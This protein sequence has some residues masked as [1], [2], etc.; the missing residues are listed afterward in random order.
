[1]P[2]LKEYNAKIARLR[3]TRKMTRTM[4]LVSANKLRR[5]QELLQHVEHCDRFL[6]GVLARLPR[7]TVRAA[8]C[9]PDR[10][11]RA[12]APR[13]LAL[14]VTSDRGLCG[15]FNASLH[16]R[17]VQWLQEREGRGEETALSYCGRRGYLFFR[18]RVTT[19]KYYRVR[20]AVPVFSEAA[21][22]FAEL[23]AA[24]AAGRFDAVYLAFNRFRGSLS[25]V[26]VLER[27]LPF[28]PPEPVAGA[29][30]WEGRQLHP[31]PPDFAAHAVSQLCALRVFEALV[32]SAAGEHGARMAAMDGSTRNVENLIENYSLLR[33]RARQA[34]ITRE[35]TE[36]V[37]G[38]EA[39]N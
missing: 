37:S 26:P 33:N 15:G 13:V 27:L 12:P 31:A 34:A 5:S 23:R 14:L 1:M 6:R 11:G 4:K 30:P 21:R 8:A 2:T 35:L 18:S 10:P 7:D 28:D 36:I 32:A 3:S 25:Q 20:S 19:E 24:H 9:A 17:T 22:I 16:R 29:E 39:L 38:A